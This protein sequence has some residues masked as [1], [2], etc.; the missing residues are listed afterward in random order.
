MKLRERQA[1]G[2]ILGSTDLDPV[3]SLLGRDLLV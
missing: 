3:D 1:G 2:R